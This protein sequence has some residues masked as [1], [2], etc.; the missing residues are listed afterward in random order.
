MIRWI[1]SLQTKFQTVSIT[2]ITLVTRLQSALSGHGKLR[3]ILSTTVLT[4]RIVV[5][6]HSQ[7]L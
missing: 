7:T 1:I 2:S 6:T 4:V 3:H 5:L